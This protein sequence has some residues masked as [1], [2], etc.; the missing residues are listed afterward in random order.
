MSAGLDHLALQRDL[1]AAFAAAVRAAD[2]DASV[3]GCPGWTARQLVGH[4]GGV[5]AWAAEVVGSGD[6]AAWRDDVAPAAPDD[7]ADWYAE[8]ADVLLAQLSASDPDEPC[9]NFTGLHLDKGFWRRRQVHET[10][11]HLDDLRSA[12]GAGADA[13]VPP[14]VW[15]DT[16][17]EVLDTWM[18]GLIRRGVAP[19]VVEPFAVVASDAGVAW[20]LTP[21]PEGEPLPG[22]A[23]QAAGDPLPNTRVTGRAAAVARLMWKRAPLR[24]LDV[25]GDRAVVEAYLANQLTS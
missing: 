8:R 20:V 18:P 4:L 14:R 13:E 19:V 3:P 17:A 24:A 23:E 7:A 25:A 21:P 15:A 10:L 12:T 16:V 2:L 6:R 9:W 22:C 5:H 11:V 1:A